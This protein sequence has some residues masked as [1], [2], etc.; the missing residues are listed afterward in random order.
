MLPILAS[1]D[2][3]PLPDLCL[4][5]VPA[6]ARATA[7]EQQRAGDR[8]AR[9]SAVEQLLWGSPEAR[10]AAGAVGGPRWGASAGVLGRLQAR[11]LQRLLAVAV[12]YVR[13]EV[14]DVEVQ[15]VQA[16]VHY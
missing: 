15:Y 13:V 16:S 4:Q 7:E 3:C 5:P 12:Q 14:A 11:A 1:P 2:A 9:L 6:D 8:A 10:A